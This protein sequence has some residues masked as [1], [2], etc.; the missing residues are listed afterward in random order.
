MSGRLVASARCYNGAVTGERWAQI[1]I[2]A[3]FRV[4]VRTLGEIFR[5]QHVHGAAFS[6]ALA[7]PYIGGALIA[8]CAC[9]LGVI[10]FFFRRYALSAWFALATVIAL[11]VYKINVMG[12]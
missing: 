11:L 10:L 5:L 2:T 4:V 1:G 3:Q 7:M 9:W 8:A 12:R 6:I